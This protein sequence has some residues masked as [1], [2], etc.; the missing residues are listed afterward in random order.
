VRRVLP[1]HRVACPDGLVH[2]VY[3]VDISPPRIYVHCPNDFPRN[4]VQIVL[5]QP[6][7]CVVC[8]TCELRGDA[9]DP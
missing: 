2:L 5:T 8:L 4:R 9:D 1:G 3:E 7:T 6:L